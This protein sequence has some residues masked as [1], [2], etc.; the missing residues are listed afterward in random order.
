M[1]Q[2]SGVFETH[3]KNYCDQIAG[4]DFSS[5]VDRLGIEQDGDQVRIRF[6]ARDYWVSGAGIRDAS[7][8]R[9]DYGLCV[10]Q[11]KY[12]LLCPEQ[13][14]LDTQWVS[15]K[16]FKKDSHFTNVNFFTSDT[17]QA[18]LKH[19]SGRRSQLLAAC[20]KLGGVPHDTGATYDLSIPVGVLPRISL[21]LLYNDA[22]DMFPAQCTVL[23]QKHAEF[24]LGPESLVMVGA[25]LAKHLI[26]ADQEMWHGK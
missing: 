4:L 13:I 7:G 14:H 17:E 5:I 6:L 22:E 16:D 19:F 24:Y 10:I 2:R 20:R 3:Y 9:P 15:F 18:I 1:S 23:F 11:A 21:L 26:K 8:K 12:L 25:G